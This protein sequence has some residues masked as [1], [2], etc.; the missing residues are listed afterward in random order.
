M[1]IFEQIG[2]LFHKQRA[3]MLIS[4]LGETCELSTSEVACFVH[5]NVMHWLHTKH[6]TSSITLASKFGSE[7]FF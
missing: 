4:F 1:Y 5:K 6:T 3:V 2:S 7:M